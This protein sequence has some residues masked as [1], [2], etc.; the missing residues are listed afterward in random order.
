[1]NWKMLAPIFLYIGIIGLT[2]YFLLY[3]PQ[4]KQKKKID[5]MQKNVKVGDNVVTIGGIV[6]IVL[7]IDK[8]VLVLEVSE[9][10]DQ[11]R[12]V[13]SAIQKVI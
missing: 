2:F 9:N 6:G 11:L 3:L 1:M 4:K 12:V 8:D 13:R 5:A 7:Q 10:N